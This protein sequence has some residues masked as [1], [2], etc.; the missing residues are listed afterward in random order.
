MSG[1]WR[2]TS[3]PAST[4]STT[5][6]SWIG[7]DAVG[8]KRVLGLVEAF[9]KAG[10]LSE[11]GIERDTSTG[12]PQEGILSPLLANIALS[13][14]DDHFAEAWATM[15]STSS[16]AKSV[17]ARDWPPTASSATRTIS[18]FWCPA[19]ASTPK[20][21]RR[22]WRRGQASGE[23]SLRERERS[24]RASTQCAGAPH[25][26]RAFRPPGS[27]SRAMQH[28][29]VVTMIGLQ[30]G[31]RL[32]Q[33]LPSCRLVA[34]ENC[35]VS[36][37]EQIADCWSDARRERDSR[38]A[39][40]TSVMRSPGR[41]SAPGMWAA[42]RASSS[43]SRAARMSKGAYVLAASSRSPTRRRPRRSCSGCC[44]QGGWLSPAGGDP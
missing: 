31:E 3:R 35:D 14:L 1:C 17:D 39:D 2:V 21:C 44:L 26:H 41:L 38:A 19:P 7:W 18:W 13:V 12:T 4:R 16:A 29:L 30:C 25:R 32:R 36:V 24:F 43:V 37:Q 34:L 6:L 8:D 42:A 9:L 11:D 40:A 5:P 33:S 23:R 15:G 10:I 27:P 20:A 28:R 22:R